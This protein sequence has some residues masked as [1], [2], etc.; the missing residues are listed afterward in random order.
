M[1]AM[2]DIDDFLPEVLQYVPGT[3]DLVVQRNVVKVARELCE[4][5][6]LWREAVT[7]TITTPSGQAFAP[8]DN[9]EIHQIEHA[10]IGERD[11]EPVTV[12]F[13]DKKYPTWSTTDEIGVARYITQLELNTMA[14]YPREAG[15]AAVRLLLKPSVRAA[16]LPQFLLDSYSEEIGRGAA[17]RI[18]VLPTAAANPQ[19]GLDHRAWFEKRLDVLK[20]RV[21]KGQQNAPLRTKGSYF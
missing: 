3:A 12:A 2:V 15:T 17:A 7:V 21:S 13:L 1:V 19:L 8:I 9:A 4:A 10:T 18:L 5:A 14:V 20:A 11:L 6:K 16:E